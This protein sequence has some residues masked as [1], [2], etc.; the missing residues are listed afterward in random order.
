MLDEGLDFVVADRENGE[1]DSVQ[2]Y[3][4]E[5]RRI[6]LLSIEEETPVQLRMAIVQCHHSSSDLNLL[7][8]SLS[9]HAVGALTGIKV[10]ASLL[11]GGEARSFESIPGP[12]LRKVIPAGGIWL[13]DGHDSTWLGE[14]QHLAEELGI[15]TNWR[16]DKAHMHQIKELVRQ[17]GMIG[18]LFDDLDVLKPCLLNEGTGRS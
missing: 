7:Q 16:K 15:T 18:V 9:Q 5:I 2:V 14:G 4:R 12:V 6:P 11:E 1:V 13:L 8:S 17:A 3:L 10:P